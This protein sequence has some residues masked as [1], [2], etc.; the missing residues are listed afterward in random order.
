MR[1]ISYMRPGLAV[2]EVEE[3]KLRSPKDVKIKIAYASICGS[4]FHI[5]HGHYDQLYDQLFP[6]KPKGYGMGHE[7]CGYVVEL[8]S[9]ATTKG[10]KVGDKVA[11]YFNQYCGKCH[12]C[13]NGKEQFCTNKG[14]VIDSMSDCIIVDEQQAY[15][16]DDDADMQAASLVEPISICM[17]GVDMCRIK[18][19]TTVAVNG[20]GGIGLICMQLAKMSGAVRLTMIE[21][22]EEKRKIALECG[23]DFVVD[24]TSQD[25]VEESMK[26]TGG[27]GYDVVIEASGNLR[28]MKTAYDITGFGSILEY[29]AVYPHGTTYDFMDT[30]N[31]FNKELTVITGVMQ[32]PY[33]L[34]RSVEVYKHLNLKP[35]TSTGIFQPEE[36]EAAFE[37]QRTGKIIKGIFE[38]NKSF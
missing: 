14:M 31:G 6:N 33:T 26:I 15:K 22:V 19:G 20:C 18:P 21:P 7:A 4:D 27:L 24:P 36:C 34:Q 28:A 1:Q 12:Y 16:L 30:D 35:I 3:P 17:H 25:V 13:R 5:L 10:L 23:A 8:G 32:S 29:I 9:E 2:L 11:Y 38:F 37:A